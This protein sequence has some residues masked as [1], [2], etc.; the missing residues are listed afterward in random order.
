MTRHNTNKYPSPREGLNKI[1][2]IYLME[3]YATLKRN[4]TIYKQLDGEK[5][6][7]CSILINGGRTIIEETS[8]TKQPNTMCEPCLYSDFIY[9]I[10]VVSFHETTRGN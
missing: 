9:Y 8:E 3:P 10:K 7:V 5:Y 4:K 6:V 1:W 2:Y